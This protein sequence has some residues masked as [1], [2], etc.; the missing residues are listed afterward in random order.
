MAS[1]DVSH[2]DG[3]PPLTQRCHPARVKS[4]QTPSESENVVAR[5]T[6]P[7]LVRMKKGSDP[8]T[9]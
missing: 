7:I 3:P 9:Y 8:I 5:E 1:R 2:F 4:G 6:V